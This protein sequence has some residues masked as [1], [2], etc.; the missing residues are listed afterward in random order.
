MC[1]WWV[2]EPMHI[3][4]DVHIFVNQRANLSVILLIPFALI[5]FETGSLTDQ[6]VSCLL[7]ELSFQSTMITGSCWYILMSHV[8]S[9]NQI[10]R[11]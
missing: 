11:L 10:H 1:F 4:M 9:A 3:S 5:F 2:H 8:G 6:Q 7:R